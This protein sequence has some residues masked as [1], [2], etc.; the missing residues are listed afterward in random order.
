MMIPECLSKLSK[1][2]K[3]FA[4]WELSSAG[5]SNSLASPRGIK[6]PCLSFIGCQ[7]R[8]KSSS[9]KERLLTHHECLRYVL[10]GFEDVLSMH[11]EIAWNIK[12]TAQCSQN[13]TNTYD[14]TCNRWHSTRKASSPKPKSSTCSSTR[15]ILRTIVSPVHLNPNNTHNRFSSVGTHNSFFLPTLRKPWFQESFKHETQM[16]KSARTEGAEAFLVGTRDPEAIAI[17]IKL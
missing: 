6:P 7:Y 17:A 1:V 16:A 2:A 12:I 15:A 9:V 4:D 5:W 3:S 13:F 8:S 11:L 14:T 10:R